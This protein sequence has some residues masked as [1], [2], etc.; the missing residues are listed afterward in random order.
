[1]S[2][3]FAIDVTDA[4]FQ[5]NVIEASMHQ[6][7]LVDFWATWC[8]PC[9]VLKP[10]L[11]QLADE[12]QGKFLLA[13]VN[14]EEN[15]Q[16]AMMFN[17]RSIPTIKLFI[18]GEPVDEFMGALPEPQIRAF[19]EKHIQRESDIMVKQAEELLLQ[20]QSD[21]ALEL[22]KQANQ[23][24]PGNH[25]V[26]LAYARACATIGNLE[27]AKTVID[28]LPAEMQES[29]DVIALKNQMEFDEMT[30]DSAPLEE[31]LSKLADNPDD[32]ETRYQLAAQQMMHSETESALDNL[33]LIMKKDRAF[34]DDAA[35]KMMFKIFDTLGADNPLVGLYRRKLMSLI[36]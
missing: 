13:K 20:G 23:A 29:T 28:A 36:Y 6:P 3:P 14:T 22:I 12:F 35:R 5:Q 8:Q 15:Q 1:M 17:I 32:L 9:Q 11:E 31:L 24:D 16:V 4:D 30:K 33:L 26:L 34:N 25:R 19:I 21:E 18:N 7:V 27:E 10:M 2:S